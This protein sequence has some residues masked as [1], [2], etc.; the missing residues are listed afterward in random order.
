MASFIYTS[1]LPLL[2]L[3]RKLEIELPQGGAIAHI[4]KPYLFFFF[5]YDS[6]FPTAIHLQLSEEK[7][8]NA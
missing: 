4:L 8:T 7:I 2:L 6:A 3:S 1:N 5:L